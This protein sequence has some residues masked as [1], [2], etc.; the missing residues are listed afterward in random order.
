MRKVF[1]GMA[2]SLDGYIQSATSDLSWL[3]DSMANDEDYGFQSTVNRTGAYIIGA[4]TY[5]DMTGMGGGSTPT[6]N[7]RQIPQNKQNHT[8]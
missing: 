6:Y 4:N 8:S 7:A 5:R 3:N 1:G 2:A